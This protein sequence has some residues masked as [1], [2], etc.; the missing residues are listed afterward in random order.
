MS[1]WANK[2]PL[3]LLLKPASPTNHR[4][5]GHLDRSTEILTREYKSCYT[6]RFCS[7]E[8][9]L[10]YRCAITMPCVTAPAHAAQE[11]QL[12][13]G[14][15][16]SDLVTATDQQC[17]R[18]HSNTP[19]IKKWAPLTTQSSSLRFVSAAEHYITEQSSKTGRTKPLKHLPR[20]SL[21]WNTYQA[22]LKIPSH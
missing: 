10:V 12:E 8:A 17:A 14:A 4:I 3:A 19:P 7:E 22:F 18:S 6:M 13:E 15:S 5:Q 21:S 1:S 20:S 11:E 2:K 9:H 16:T